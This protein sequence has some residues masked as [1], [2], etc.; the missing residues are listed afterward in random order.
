M[1]KKLTLH[2]TDFYKNLILKLNFIH[3]TNI[4]INENDISKYRFIFIGEL[5]YGIVSWFPYLNFLNSKGINFKTLMIKGYKSFCPFISSKSDHV[6]VELKHLDSWGTFKQLMSLKKY[7]KGEILISPFNYKYHQTNISIGGYK[8]QNPSFHN[9]INVTNYKKLKIKPIKTF[10]K[11]NNIKN[12]YWVINIKKHF[13]WGNNF[14]ENYY[15]FDEIKK[16]LNYAK[17]ENITVFLNDTSLVEDASQVDLFNLDSFVNNQN[18]FNLN[19]LYKKVRKP[20]EINQIQ[21]EYLSNADHVFSTQG[22]NS[23]ISILL[24]KSS[25]II[26]RG[27]LDFID[28]TEMAKIYNRDIEI[29]YELNQS[30]ILKL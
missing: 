3:T 18:V 1:N 12:K 8:W 15:S 28:L 6:E 5:G 14:I 23:L 19:D 29:I 10:L 27:G 25:T 17:E 7:L 9:P 30:K 4:D 2:N 22:G 16:I 24:A 21:F 11:K 13:N 26:M 20:D